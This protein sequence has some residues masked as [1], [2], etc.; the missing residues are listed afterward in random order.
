MTRLRSRSRLARP[1]IRTMGPPQPARQLGERRRTSP[2][3]AVTAGAYEDY[4]AGQGARYCAPGLGDSRPEGRKSR[5]RGIWPVGLPA[6]TGVGWNVGTGEPLNCCSWPS[7][8]HQTPSRMLPRQMHNGASL[9][10][11]LWAG[12]HPSVPPSK[13]TGQQGRPARTVRLPQA[14]TFTPAGDVLGPGCGPQLS[15][16]AVSWAATKAPWKYRR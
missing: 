11:R 10:G 8:A 1:Y 12:P 15:G 2:G 13:V 9:P 3:S 6:F 16:G 14:S 4:Q 7:H 5:A